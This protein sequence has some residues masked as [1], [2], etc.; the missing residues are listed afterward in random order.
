MTILYK[1]ESRVFQSA[2]LVLNHISTLLRRFAR[3]ANAHLSDDETVAKMGRPNLLLV[4]PGPPA[5]EGEVVWTVTIV[6]LWGVLESFVQRSFFR[7][8]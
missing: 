4:R 5:P 3:S 6:L 7:A 1:S 2:R 8:Y